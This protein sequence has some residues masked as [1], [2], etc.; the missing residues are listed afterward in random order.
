[1]Q[2]ADVL[3]R[4]DE[5]GPVLLALQSL[6]AEFGHVHDE[7]VALVAV[8]FN[9][10]RADVYGV[11]TFYRDLRTTPPPDV[12]VRVCMGEACQAVGAAR[13]A[14][15]R[16]VARSTRRARSTGH[17]HGQL[18]ARAHRRRERPADRPCHRGRLAVGDRAGEDGP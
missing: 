18:R 6:Q 16:R 10:S 12:E 8:A 1:M 14:L 7:D 15:R 5:P 13:A 3:A 11:L 4:I 17:L 9:V 2:R